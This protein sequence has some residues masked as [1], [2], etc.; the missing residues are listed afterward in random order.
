[1]TG[2]CFGVQQTNGFLPFAWSHHSCLKYADCASLDYTC[3]QDYCDEVH[4]VVTPRA[5]YELRGKQVPAKTVTALAD[6]VGVFADVPGCE[7]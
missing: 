3:A 2:P 4:F 7:R 1:M 6:R 5:P